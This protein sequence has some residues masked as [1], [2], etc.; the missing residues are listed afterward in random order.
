VLQSE[1]GSLRGG[2]RRWFKRSTREKKF[3]IEDKLIIIIII[4]IIII[5]RITNA[6]NRDWRLSSGYHLVSR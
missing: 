4:I 3:V 5:C 1:T 2:D 6:C